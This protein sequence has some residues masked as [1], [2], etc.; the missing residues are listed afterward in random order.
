MKWVPD[1]TGR[2]ATRPHYLAEDLDAE[3]ECIVRAFLQQKYGRI[4]FPVDAV[5]QIW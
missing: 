1:T 5:E 3:C 2:F 4:E